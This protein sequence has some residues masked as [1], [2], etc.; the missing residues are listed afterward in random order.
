[1][2]RASDVRKILNCSDATASEIMLKLRELEVV[3]TDK[4]KSQFIN[5]DES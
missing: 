1:M 2:F 3:V 4:D 5:K